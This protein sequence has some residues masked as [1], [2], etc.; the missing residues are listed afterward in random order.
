[1]TTPATTSTASTASSQ[2]SHPKSGSKR[3]AQQM[4]VAT[5]GE[6]ATKRPYLGKCQYKTGKCSNERTLKR[7]GNAHSLCEEHRIK[8]NLIQRRS[9]RKYQKEH[10]IRQLVGFAPHIQGPQP[11]LGCILNDQSTMGSPLVMSFGNVEVTAQG[12]ITNVNDR[13]SPTGVDDF[14][15][16]SFQNI[17]I[18]GGDCSPLPFQYDEI[19]GSSSVGYVSTTSNKQAWSK[20]DLEFL[21]NLL[22]A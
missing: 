7:N 18:V 19:N 17:P 8:Q 22:L 11:L 5:D 3:K 1:M 20:A 14:T 12:A 9:D 16:Y 6:P 21:Q 15:Q 13:L 10:A 2:A 4:S